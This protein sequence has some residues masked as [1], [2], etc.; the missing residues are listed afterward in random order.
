[1]NRYLAVVSLVAAASLAALTAVATGQTPHPHPHPH[2]HPRAAPAHP[3]HKIAP[4]DE[5]FGRL[6][7][8]ILGIA[9]TIKDQGLKYDRQPE[10]YPSLVSSIR[11]CEDAIRDWEHKYPR[12][13]WVPKTLLSLEHFYSKVTTDEG[14]TRAKATILWLVHD[15]PKSPYSRTA[16]KELSEGK[17]GV[18]ATAAPA[19]PAAGVDITKPVLGE[20]PSPAPQK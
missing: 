11:F 16:Q 19:L 4:A 5:Y 2:P 20:S 6:K 15:F 13:P 10:S 12:D 7:M 8:S 17:I 18:A 1:M 3:A 9:N 14:R